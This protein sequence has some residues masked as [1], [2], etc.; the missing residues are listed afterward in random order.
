MQETRS[1]KDHNDFDDVIDI[2]EFFYVLLNGKR[3]IVSVTAF[4]SIIGVMYSLSLPNI[5][6]S[7]AIL[8]PID[9]SD[10][11]SN[12]LQSYSSIAGLAGLNIPFSSGAG[13]NYFKAIEKVTSLSFFE[14]NILENIYLPDL[15]AFESWDP[16]TN[17][18]V[19]DEDIY[20]IENNSWVREYSYPKQQI[21]SAQESFEA[22]KLNHFS[23]SQDKESGFSLLAIEHK[24]PI[25]ARQWAELI[26][27]EINNYYRQKDKLESEKALIYLNDQ[28]INT[29]LSEIKLVLAQLLQEE[30][31]K[32][33]LIEANEF[34]V[35]DYIDPPAVMEMKS[36][37][38]R[39]KI[40]IIIAFFG[41][42][43][44]TLFVLVRHYGFNNKDSNK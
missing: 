1:N 10:N 9:S 44:S 3:I 30:T 13:T 43:L 7:K 23:F 41:G 34:Y 40:C 15:M 32:L 2:R 14:N 31:K 19:Y 6:T 33:T 36:H 20:N 39:A 4:I 28:I 18:V 16:K 38:S 21:P 25:I 29:G 22:F 26:V 12:P 24:S 37:P 27:S 11:I 17:T 35:F 8:A 42:L 5:Y